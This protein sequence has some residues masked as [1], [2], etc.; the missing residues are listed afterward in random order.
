MAASR[1]VI[2]I[3]ERH[4]IPIAD[5]PLWARQAKMAEG[6]LGRLSGRGAS[7]K[8]GTDKNFEVALSD[9]EWRQRLTPE[10]YRVLRQHGTDRAG[11]SPLDKQHDA[12][13]YHCAPYGQTLVATS[14]TL[15]R[16]NAR[17]TSWA[18]LVKEVAR[19]TDR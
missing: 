12:G 14:S 11:T 18:R 9:E 3:T 8:T 15:N 4:N 2:F 10:Q 17:P 16:G 7:S 13:I 19:L 6:V 5:P 1:Q